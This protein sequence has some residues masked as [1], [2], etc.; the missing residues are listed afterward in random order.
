MY[1]ELHVASAIPV[2]ATS[3]LFIYHISLFEIGFFPHNLQLK[4]K[5]NRAATGGKAAKAWSLA[6]FLEIELWR[7]G[8]MA[9]LW[10]PC[11]PKIY[12]GGPE[13]RPCT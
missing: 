12:Y 3:H 4:L 9:A 8:E 6:G 11:L 7:A 13:I 10:H 1:L 2:F 5:L